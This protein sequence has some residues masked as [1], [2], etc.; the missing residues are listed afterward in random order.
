MAAY[1]RNCAYFYTNEN[2]KHQQIKQTHQCEQQ[3]KSQKT[4]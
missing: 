1:V 4:K 3:E 2:D